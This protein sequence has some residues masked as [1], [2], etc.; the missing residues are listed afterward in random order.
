MAADLA[1]LAC[2]RGGQATAAS[3]GLPRLSPSLIRAFKQTYSGSDNQDRSREDSFFNPPGSNNNCSVLGLAALLVHGAKS[4]RKLGEDLLGSMHSL[5]QQCPSIKVHVSTA[6]SM[7]AEVLAAGMQLLADDRPGTL[8]DGLARAVR[9]I[10]STLCEI[11]PRVANDTFHVSPEEVRRV[12]EPGTRVPVGALAALVEKL[13]IRATLVVHALHRVDEHELGHAANPHLGI[14]LVSHRHIMSFLAGVPHRRVGSSAGVPH[15]RVG[16]SACVPLIALPQAQTTVEELT[17]PGCVLVLMP[18]GASRWEFADARVADIM[19]ACEG[20]CELSWQQPRLVLDGVSID[21]CTGTLEDCGARADSVL[22]VLCNMTLGGCG[23]STE[24]REASPAGGAE[25]ALERLKHI[26]PSHYFIPQALLDSIE[27]G[28]IAPVRGSWLLR[29][30][31]EG[32][33]KL[34]KNTSGSLTSTVEEIGQ[35]RVRRRQDLPPEAFWRVEE[36]RK[37]LHQLG[38]GDFTTSNQHH[39]N[40]GLLFVALSYRWLSAPTPA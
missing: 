9:I 29:M 24:A 27:S 32:G 39:A 5:G 6:A 26:Q 31:K 1:S 2:W 22:R 30:W 23:A 14:L 19:V 20:L 40:Y 36:V 28:A 37:L 33:G 25:A 8:A 10:M 7:I 18:D 21:R 3:C 15:G 38:E 16:S 4:D 13:P 35:A 34:K 11:E 17:A 12:A